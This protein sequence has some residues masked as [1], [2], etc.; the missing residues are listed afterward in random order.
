ML[1]RQIR[2]PEQDAHAFDW[3][4]NCGDSRGVKTHNLICHTLSCFFVL[5]E[6]GGDMELEFHKSPPCICLFDCIIIRLPPLA[7]HANGL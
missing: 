2:L 7:S 1:E 5:D 3:V 6:T 4:G